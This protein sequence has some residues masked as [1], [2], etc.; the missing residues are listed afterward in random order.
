MK[1]CE[2][3]TEGEVKQWYND[4]VKQWYNDAALLNQSEAS[5][6][7]LNYVLPYASLKTMIILSTIRYKHSKNIQIHKSTILII[8]IK[9]RQQYVEGDQ[10]NVIV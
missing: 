4:A 6:E 5:D 1:C 7:N 9:G 10:D 3:L 8:T 2:S